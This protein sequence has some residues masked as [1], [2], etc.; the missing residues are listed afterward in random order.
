MFITTSVVN[1][2]RM[3]LATALVGL[4]AL[5]PGPARGAEENKASL[6][7]NVEQGNKLIQG[8]KEGNFRLRIDG[9]NVPFTLKEPEKPASIG[10]LVEYSESSWI[11]LRDVVGAM[12]GFTDFAPEGHW[13]ALASFAQDF[14]LEVDFTKRRGEIANGF[15]GM[16][17]PQWREIN[18]YDAL[19]TMLDRM[20]RMSGRRILIFIGSGFDTFSGRTLDDVQ[21]RVEAANVVVYSIGAGSVLR[22]QYHPYLGDT[23]RM[24]LMQARA[25]LQMLA[26]KSGGQAW[27][28]R[29]DS[30][31]RDVMKGA[32]Q[33][34]ETQYRL[35]YERRA[36][37]DGNF[38]EIEVEA[39]TV[40]NDQRQDFDVRVREGWRRG[41]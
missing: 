20:G 36:P 2:S 39:F 24:D 7:L 22:G 6:Y 15:S 11:Y 33:N 41:R 31:F 8:L 27:F 37:A 5:Q 14:T 29:F 13:Y 10:I 34:I 3:V 21:E 30:A 9:E 23:A 1:K 32:M 28:P 35:V 40:E 25:F 18:T 12:S 19:Y 38:H 16:T 4:A 17:P 26:D